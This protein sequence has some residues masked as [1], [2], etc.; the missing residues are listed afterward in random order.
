MH[1]KT[2]AILLLSYFFFSLVATQPIVNGPTSQMNPA[3]NPESAGLLP[4]RQDANGGFTHIS[5]G[6]DDLSGNDN[7]QDFLNWY[8][9]KN[10]R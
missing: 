10:D 3:S 5:S 1:L 6:L 9:E 7:F 8:L 4:K 2:E